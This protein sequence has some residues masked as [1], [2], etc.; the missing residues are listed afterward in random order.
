MIEAAPEPSNIVW[1]N[2]ESTAVKRASRKF[3][4]IVIICIFIFLTFLL[5]SALKSKA[6]KNKLMY[7][8]RTDC[9]GLAQLFTGAD[10]KVDLEAYKRHAEHDKEETGQF[11]GAGYYMCYCKKNSKASETLRH[12][13]DLCYKY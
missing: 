11:R 4:V 10:G 8:V 2:L 13:D 7:P 9:D 1:E 3:C 12:E 5:Y 6:G